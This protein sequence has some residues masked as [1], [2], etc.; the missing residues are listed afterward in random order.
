MCFAAAAM[1]VSAGGTAEA[2]IGGLIRKVTPKVKLPN[3][4]A[5]KPPISTNIKDA[6]YGDPSQDAFNPGPEM[7]LT[8]LQRSKTGGFILRAGYY[9]MEAQSYCLHAG[10]YG[11]TSGDG[12]LYAPVKGSAK[13]IVTA[14][15][16]NSTKHPEIAQRDIQ[17]LLWAVVARAKFENLNNRLKIV[18]AQLLTQKQLA[19]MNRS[20]L[21]VLTNRQVQ[22]VTGGLPEPIARIARAEADMRRMLSGGSSY[23]D[24]ESV[25]VL[26]GI[27]PRGAGSIDVPAQRW[28]KHPKGYWVRYN[29]RSY[30]RTKVEIF[31]APGSK[32]EG[33]EYDPATAIAVP[34]N[35]AKQRLGQSARVYGA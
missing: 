16:Q 1:V 23:S 12:Y 7:S 14:I 27:A 33:K 32:A 13:K 28:S 11:P 6:I 17:M 19:S 34:V 9:S 8:S 31:V 10:T 24:L 18:A 22:Q 26:A 5:G 15:L 25:A 20:A 4:L 30:S 21:D 3:L 35:T 29:A 2:Q